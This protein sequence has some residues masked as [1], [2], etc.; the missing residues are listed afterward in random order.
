MDF[1]KLTDAG[2][3]FNTKPEEYLQYLKNQQNINNKINIKKDGN[4]HNGSITIEEINLNNDIENS[5][6]WIWENGKLERICRWEN[7]YQSNRRRLDFG[8]DETDEMI[9]SYG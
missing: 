3:T 5:T 6:A 8:K 7:Q 2:I 1:S 9:I 4:K